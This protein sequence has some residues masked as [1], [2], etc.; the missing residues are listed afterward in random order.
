MAKCNHLKN[1]LY[2]FYSRNLGRGWSNDS[3]MRRHW[4]NDSKSHYKIC[5]TNQTAQIKY[6]KNIVGYNFKL[7]DKSYFTLSNKDQSGKDIF[8]SDNKE[9]TPDKEKNKYKSSYEEKILL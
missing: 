1:T 2:N 8:Y 6:F 3:K 7:D 9:K 5:Q 4:S